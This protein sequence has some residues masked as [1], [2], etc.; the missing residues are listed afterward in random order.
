[1]SDKKL[2]AGVIDTH[3]HSAPDVRE[4]KFTDLELALD[5][6]RVGARAIVIKSHVVPTM[7][8]AWLVEQAVPEVRVFGGITLNH[9]VGG[10]NLSAVDAA[11]KMGAKIVWLPTF[12]AAHEFRYYGKQGGIECVAGNDV[13]P[14][15][16]DILKLIARHDVILGTGHLSAEEIMVV[17]DRAKELGVQKIII[18]HPELV[19]INLSIADQKRL[20]SYGVFFER[21]YARRPTGCDWEKCFALNL[22]AIE[23]VGYE[24]TIIA[25]DVGQLENPMWSDAL[26]EY[27]Q[28]L[29]DAG[30]SQQAIAMM[31]RMNAAKLL[32]LA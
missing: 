20:V 8:R 1:M 32:G 7:N 24:S 27:I 6:K 10:L 30:L 16:A 22:A 18:N 31:T 2:L 4:R 13:T 9:E 26:S 15:L 3:I 21:C 5:A 14:A 19:R 23:A 28:F 11:I 29:I 12:S 25:T 17:V